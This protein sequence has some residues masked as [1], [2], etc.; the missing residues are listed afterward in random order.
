MNEVAAERRVKDGVLRL[1][2]RSVPGRK[3]EPVFAQEDLD[4]LVKPKQ[5]LVLKSKPRARRQLEANGQNG[6]MPSDH[7]ASI[8]AVPL[9]RKL[10][11][12]VPEAKAYGG[13]PEALLLEKIHVKELRAIL[14]GKYFIS[15]LDLERLTVF[16]RLV[17]VGHAGGR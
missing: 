7:H 13:L 12:T 14:R 4:K 5:P 1:E 2:Y 11:L 10:F 15:R 9:H 17:D 16:D 8:P 6:I 3:H